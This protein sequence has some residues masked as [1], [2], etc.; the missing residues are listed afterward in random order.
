MSRSTIESSRI[1]DIIIE[2]LN[3]TNVSKTPIQSGIVNS[4][5]EIKKEG[6]DRVE[7]CILN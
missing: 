1:A 7:R 6:F 2:A 5:S 3:K 4:L